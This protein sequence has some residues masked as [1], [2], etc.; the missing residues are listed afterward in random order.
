MLSP[1]E[2]TVL[3]DKILE[4]QPG[5]ESN[6]GRGCKPTGLKLFTEHGG[7]TLF[8]VGELSKIGLAHIV[9]GHLYYF[10]P[11]SD[12]ALNLA[13]QG[14]SQYPPLTLK[15]ALAIGESK[16]PLNDNEEF[17]ISVARL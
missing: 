9:L 7:G 12:T 1:E 2:L 5:F 3:Q 8:W 15:E 4:Y 6:R 17:F 14:H 10:T 16:D 13:D 11:D